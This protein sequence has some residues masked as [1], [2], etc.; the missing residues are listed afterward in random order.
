[1]VLQKKAESLASE[2]KLLQGELADYNIVI[3]KMNVNEG[4]DDIEHE[5]NELKVKKKKELT[6]KTLLYCF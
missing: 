2:L 6:V 3:D 1:M 5:C 4:V